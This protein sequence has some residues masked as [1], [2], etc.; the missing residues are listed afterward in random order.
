MLGRWQSQ[1]QCCA[2]E[3]LYWRSNAVVPTF[4][5]ISTECTREDAGRG[6]SIADD[7]GAFISRVV[8]Q[9]VV[10]VSGAFPASRIRVDDE[11][12]CLV[13]LGYWQQ[14]NGGTYCTVRVGTVRVL[15]TVGYREIR[16]CSRMIQVCTYK[17]FVD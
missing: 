7:K 1:L 11:R 14:R 12:R 9:Y 4:I 10:L 5:T 13:V 17:W 6:S 15:C 2:E 8:Q 3:E 16:F